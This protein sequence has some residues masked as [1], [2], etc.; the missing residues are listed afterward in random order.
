MWELHTM[1]KTK[2]DISQ[3]I[4]QTFNRLTLIEEIE[5]MRYGTTTVRRALFKCNCGTE[6][7]IYLLNVVSGQIKSCG[8]INKGLAKKVTHGMSYIPEHGI[9]R[10]M[11]GR[12]L[13]SKHPDYKNYGARGIKV[14][15]RWLDP[16]HGY[17]NFI[18]DMGER[19]SKKHSV[20]RVDND[21]DYTPKNCKW[22]TPSEQALNKRTSKKNRTHGTEQ[23]QIFS[24]T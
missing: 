13:S 9:W 7:A 20:E 11:K 23:P 15:D 21:G 16:I 4:G 10:N 24:R 17:N 14:C 3:L 2:K 18:T 8:C 5:P 6:K 19:P 22:A 12:C 1:G